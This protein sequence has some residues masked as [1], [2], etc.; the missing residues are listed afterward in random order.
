MYVK[1]KT[2]IEGYYKNEEENKKQF[3]EEGWFKTGDI[4]ELIGLSKI[5]IIDR[6]KN[7]F[8]LAQVSYFSFLN[9]V[10]FTEIV[11]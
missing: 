10:P 2:M 8:K 4:V 1:T 3:D 11:Y 9:N 6:K 5:R 7:I